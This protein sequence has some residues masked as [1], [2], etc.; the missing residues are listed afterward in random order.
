MMISSSGSFSAYSLRVNFEYM[1][2]Q[3]TTQNAGANEEPV[4][5]EPVA[6][7]GIQTDADDEGRALDAAR[8]AGRRA[9][10]R[11]GDDDDHERR[12]HGAAPGSVREARRIGRSVGHE[13]RPFLRGNG[14]LDRETRHELRAAFHDLRHDLR[15]A[16]SSATGEEGFDVEAFATAA[17]EAVEGFAADFAAAFGIEIVQ[18]DDAA[19][20]QDDLRSEEDPVVDD[21]AQGD[22]SVDTPIPTMGTG[23]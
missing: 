9:G 17:A 20:D 3:G 22:R 21:V 2:I 13:V 8:E 16:A 7:A 14:G 5:V 18:D 12:D 6:P 11:D 19:E 10:M 23:V 4:I 15:D 1:K